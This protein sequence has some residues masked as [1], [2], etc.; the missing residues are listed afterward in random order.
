MTV[1]IADVAQ[2]VTE[3]GDGSQ[4]VLESATSLSDEA[5]KLQRE[6]GDFLTQVRAG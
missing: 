2:A 4:Q 3:T 5:A 6:V 1:N